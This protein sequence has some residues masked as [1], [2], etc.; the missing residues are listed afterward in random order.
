MMNN[1]NLI[2]EQYKLAIETADKTTDRRYNFNKF[3]IT[4]CTALVAGIG[5]LAP[6][7][8]LYTIPI[9]ILGYIICDIWIK[10][11][12]CFKKMIKIKYN[13][14]KRIEKKYK[15]ILNT[16]IIEF[17]QREQEKKHFFKSFSEQEKDVANTF[18]IGFILYLL[19]VFIIYC[20]LNSIT[21]TLIINL[22]L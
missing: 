15:Y 9:A 10:Q 6:H 22:F 17:Q 18:K 16:Y 20:S 14:V 1:K 4:I 19:L 21:S 13:S 8:P 3:M 11:I 5:A 12:N 7:C 2:F